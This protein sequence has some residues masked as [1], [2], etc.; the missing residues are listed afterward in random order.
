MAQQEIVEYG[1]PKKVLL[2]T[3]SVEGIP[4]GLCEPFNGGATSIIRPIYPFV[5]TEAT[6]V[7]E[8]AAYPQ[9]RF[10]PQEGGS[11]QFFYITLRK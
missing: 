11:D 5:L 8:N 3:D 7:G 10:T 6:G 9:E 4:L 2:S 1:N